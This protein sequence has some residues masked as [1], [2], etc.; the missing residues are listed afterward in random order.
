MIIDKHLFGHSYHDNCIQPIFVMIIDQ[1]VFDQCLSL[2]NIYVFGLPCPQSIPREKDDIKVK[3]KKHHKKSIHLS[4]SIQEI[5]YVV[6]YSIVQYV[7]YIHIQDISSNYNQMFSFKCSALRLIESV[8]IRENTATIQL[9]ISRQDSSI[10]LSSSSC[11]SFSIFIS[12]S[13]CISSSNLTT[14]H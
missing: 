8:L 2:I 9:P 12:I 10:S 14:Q 1:Y 13:S 11:I 5:L 6:Q 4:A 7:Q 3:L